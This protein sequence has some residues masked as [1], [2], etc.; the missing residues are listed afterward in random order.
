M[1]HKNKYRS[2]DIGQIIGAAIFIALLVGL[3]YLGL[4]SET[5]EHFDGS[6]FED[7]G[8]VMQEKE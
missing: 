2:V 8:K 3:I 6:F 7:I 1:P 4:N 5:P